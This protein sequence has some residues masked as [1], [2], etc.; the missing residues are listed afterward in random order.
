MAARWREPT[1]GALG[2]QSPSGC[3]NTAM[4]AFEAQVS[5]QAYRTWGAVD[6]QVW[7]PSTARSS[8]AELERLGWA[9]SRVTLRHRA[10]LAPLPQAAIARELGV[11]QPT[12]C[13]RRRVT[14]AGLRKLLSYRGDPDRDAAIVVEMAR[15]EDLVTRLAVRTWAAT[16]RRAPVAGVLDEAY[17]PDHRRASEAL[18]E[19]LADHA[20]NA[21]V[22]RLAGV[23]LPAG[24]V[25]I[26]G[27]DVD[28]WSRWDAARS[29]AAE[30]LLAWRSM[31]EDSRAA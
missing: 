10:A 1:D 30:R 16:G 4:S 27:P 22:R 23:H 8:D 17:T 31:A 5:W 11:S 24:P 6:P 15:G 26:V 28:A 20:S 18:V 14:L 19:W 21:T 13:A 3:G 29:T 2:R 25:L 12:V 9:M 7:W